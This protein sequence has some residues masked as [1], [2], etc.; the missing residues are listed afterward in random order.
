M[1]CVVVEKD[2]LTPGND[3]QADSFGSSVGQ[4]LIFRAH[5]VVDEGKNKQAVSREHL[6]VMFM[7]MS[8]TPQSVPLARL[9]AS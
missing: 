9:P 6:Y 7:F 8:W 1:A 3:G 2:V 5:L 4:K